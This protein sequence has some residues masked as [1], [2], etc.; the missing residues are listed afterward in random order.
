[1]FNI[2]F[3]CVMFYKAFL[4]ILSVLPQT[5]ARNIQFPLKDPIKEKKKGKAKMPVSE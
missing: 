4:K 5:K 3:I 1:M 2:N